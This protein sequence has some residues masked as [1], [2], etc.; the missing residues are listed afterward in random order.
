MANLLSN[1]IKNREIK[2]FQ[3]PDDLYQAAAEDFTRRAIAAVKHKGVFTVVLAGG[4][5]PK[6]FFSILVATEKYK[7][8]IPWQQILF[9]FGDERCVPVTDVANNYHMACQSLFSKVAVPSQ[10]IYRIPTEY[11]DPDE[12]ARQYELTLRRVLH[13]QDHELPQFDLQYLGMG[14]DG[15]TAS[16]MPLSDIVK[17][18]ANHSEENYQLVAAL[19]VPKL[20]MHRITLTP[21]T[22]NNSACIIFLVTGENKAFALSKVLEGPF[23]AEQYPAQLIQSTQGKTIW[24]IDQAAASSLNS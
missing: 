16:L 15:H 4:N 18:Y 20:N 22:I 19:W 12:M 5:T 14:E 24:L 13:L 9:F 3:R 11:S 6:V 10:N 8:R 21:R 17:K 7:N 23:A 2:I 1:E